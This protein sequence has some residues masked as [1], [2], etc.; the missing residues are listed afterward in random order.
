MKVCALKGNWSPKGEAVS[1]SNLSGL[2]HG[3]VDLDEAE[4]LIKETLS[5]E[6]KI[7]T[8]KERRV[9][10]PPCHHT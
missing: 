7:G 2:A 6:R 4:R 1:L 9:L 10:S 5:I 8:K 3:R